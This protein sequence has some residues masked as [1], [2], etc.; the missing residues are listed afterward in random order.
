MY[1]EVVVHRWELAKLIC[2]RAKLTCKRTNLTRAEKQRS[3]L[4]G[5]KIRVLLHQMRH[6]TGTSPGQ[7]PA[8][9]D[10]RIYVN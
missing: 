3:R 6:G 1:D 7:W 10:T 2:E 5:K 8:L 4:H 9:A